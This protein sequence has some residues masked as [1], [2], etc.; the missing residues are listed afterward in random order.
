MRICSVD[1]CNRPHQARDLCSTHYNQ[2]YQPGRHRKILVSCDWCGKMCDKEVGRE[3][4]YRNLFCS[5]TCRA[6]WAQWEAG[7]NFCVIPN[8]HPAHPEYVP[9]PPPLTPH[10][11]RIRRA[12]LRA[13]RSAPRVFVCG[14]CYRCGSDYVAEDYSNTAQYCSIRCSRRINEQRYRAR[15]KSAYV[16]DVSPVKIFERDGW[17]CQLCGK[18]VKRDKV[19]PHPLAPVLDH[20]IPLAA[21][22]DAGGTH[23]PANTQ[24]AH[25]LCN[26]I[27][28][29]RIDVQQMAL[30]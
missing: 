21:G 11:Q 14:S 23:E 26:S 19:V 28:S 25:F 30:F 2:T 9:P 4:R 15:K 17:R 24:C 22:V 6:S 27:K 1:A 12:H 29:D 13:D 5:L 18:K 10:E 3:K 8:T 7:T 16:A 20:V